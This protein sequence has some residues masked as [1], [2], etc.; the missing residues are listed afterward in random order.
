MNA[1]TLFNI[2]RDNFSS[3]TL[4]PEDE[5][6]IYNSSSGDFIDVETAEADSQ[7]SDF[8]IIIK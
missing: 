8:H 6:K 7:T 5:I 3:G 2:L 1:Q 4:H